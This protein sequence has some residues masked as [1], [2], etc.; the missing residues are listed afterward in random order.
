MTTQDKWSEWLLHR[1]FGGDAEAAEKGMRM[2]HGVRDSVL[3]AANLDDGATLLD[4]GAGDGLIAF[5]ALDRIGANGRVIFCDISRPLLDHAAS[6][7]KDLGVDDRCSFVEAPA[8]DL[9]Q[10]ADASVDAVTTR[11][12]LIYV[13][14]KAAALR[15]FHRVLRPGRTI[16]LWEP[17]NSFG[18]R[19]GA[20][21]PSWG[22]EAPEIA[23]LR[24]RIRAYYEKRQPPDTDPMLDF[25]ERD[26]LAHAEA[27]GFRRIVVRLNVIVRPAEPQKWDT[28][29][30]NAGN[31]NI[32][33]LREAMDELFNEQER[34]RFERY[35]RPVV[36]AG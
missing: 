13:P 26:L 19:Y 2:L 14:D 15:E 17:I 25:D 32:P 8:D 28:V 4:V 9:S 11:S 16:S 29:L 21:V 10:I 23:D 20:R 34:T 27:A 7:A 3:D 5:G 6:I 33:T 22:K 30:D 12:V 18:V 24:D 31:P 1:R 35:S 36:E